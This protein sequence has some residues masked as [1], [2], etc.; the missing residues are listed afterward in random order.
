MNNRSTI[1]VLLDPE[2]I[3][4]HPTNTTLKEKLGVCTYMNDKH[5]ILIKIINRY[6][7]QIEQH[8]A[9][10]Q[11]YFFI[12]AFTSP[13]EFQATIWTLDDLQTKKSGIPQQILNDHR[14]QGYVEQHPPQYTTAFYAYDVGGHKFAA[15][16]VNL[17]WIQL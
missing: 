7:P 14:F 2:D 13:Q 15:S 1:A 11:R 16:V 8:I 4:M 3:G 6:R 17:P 12:I 10:Q 5:T 9:N